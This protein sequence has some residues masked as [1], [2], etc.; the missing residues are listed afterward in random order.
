MTK[1]I[2]YYSLIQFCPDPVAAET[3][4]IG[5]VAFCPKTGF[6]DVHVSGDNKRVIRTFGS[7]V[8]HAAALQKYKEGLREWILDEHSRFAS[9]EEAQKFIA[10]QV[11]Q[12]VFIDPRP[13]VW[14]G[15]AKEGSLRLFNRLLQNN[16]KERT[17]R[18][19]RYFPKQKIISKLREKLGL[20]FD[21]KIHTNLPVLET[22]DS[23]NT[24]EPLFGFQNGFFNA[25]FARSFTEKKLC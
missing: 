16:E 15:G 25:V 14:I 1:E 20:Q 22:V 5:L 3:I 23:E 17:Y 19:S 13:T 4:N 12:I 9:L 8:C 7:K 2:G 11:N 21:Q 18:L 24:V 10:E 6:V